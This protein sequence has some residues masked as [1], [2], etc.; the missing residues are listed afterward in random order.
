MFLLSSPYSVTRLN[1]AK[2]LSSVLGTV[3][4]NAKEIRSTIL[5]TTRT[6]GT[7]HNFDR[8][9]AEHTGRDCGG[10][11]FNAFKACLPKTFAALFFLFFNVSNDCKGFG[12]GQWSSYKVNESG[13]S[14]GQWLTDQDGSGLPRKFSEGELHKSNTGQ[15]VATALKKAVSLNPDTNEGALQKVLCGFMFVF[16]WDD[17]LTGHACLFLYE[18]C[19]KV[20]QGSEDLFQGK[21]KEHSGAFKE[22]CSALKSDLQ[23]FIVGDSGLSAV[24]HHNNSNN[25][26][27]N[28]WKAEAFPFYVNWLKENIDNIKKSLQEMLKDSSNWTSANLKNA[29]SAGPFKYGFVLKDDSWK[30]GKINLKLKPFIEGLTGSGPGSLV[31]LKECLENFSTGNPGAT[32]GGV[33]TGL[34]GTGGLGAGAAYA[35]NAF[36]F[37][38]LITSFISGFLK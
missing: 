36:G 14:L 28:I 17:A 29:D 13:N 9:H 16:P 2:G 15:K 24:C 4:T 5:E 34:F 1:R 8:E 30:D 21:Y 31:K 18:F 20:S 35:T 10:K 7:Y 19:S 26:F 32:A 12:G 25:L 3:F 38:N 22:V 33:F 23:P 6:S 37:Q 27:D 11:Y